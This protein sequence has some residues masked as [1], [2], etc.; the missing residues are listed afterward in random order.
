[1]SETNLKSEIR[2]PKPDKNAKPAIR[3][4]KG[5]RASRM[6]AFGFGLRTSAFFRIAPL[7]VS[8]FCLAASFVVAAF[9]GA[10]CSPEPANRFQGYIEGE[11]V[12][13][14]APLG[15]TL[16]NLAVARGDS[17]KSGQLLF[18]LERQSEADAL[19]QE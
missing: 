5:L 19:E 6:I 8:A 18:A 15:G 17:V 14:A 1:M 12:Y 16:T 10:G 11:Y 13:V 3:T 9:L 7:R 4:P 2:N